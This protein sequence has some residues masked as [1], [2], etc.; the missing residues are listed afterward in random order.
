MSINSFDDSCVSDTKALSSIFDSTSLSLYYTYFFSSTTIHLGSICMGSAR[1][2]IS[3][4]AVTS[5]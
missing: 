5:Y 3:F 4:H 2:T 1:G